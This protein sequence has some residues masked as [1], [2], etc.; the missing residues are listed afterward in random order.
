M[1]LGEGNIAAARRAI[2]ER[3]TAAGCDAPDLDAR[4]LLEHVIGTDAAALSARADEPLPPDAADRLEVLVAER[5]RGVPLAHLLGEW[6]F[7]SLPLFV[8]PDVLVPRPETELLVEWGVELLRDLPAPRIADL[9]TGSGCIALALATELPGARVDAV[10]IS[11]AALDVAARNRARHGLDDRVRLHHGDLIAPL[12]APLDGDGCYDLIVSNPPYIAPGDPKL[13][14]G[15]AAH[16]PALALF[17]P[18]GGAGLGFYDR[19]VAE[20][21]PRLA[22]GGSVI[23]ELPEDGAD[24]V[25][26][27][28]EAAGC[29]VEV[30]RD[31]AGIERALRATPA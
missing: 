12:D 20:A 2:V 30:R 22:A 27:R 18:A 19:I 15:V 26:A 5:E 7:W 8:T 3:L 13:E 21:V 23:V 31:L 25:R 14:A 29:A 28:F 17:D 4:W 10:D 1:S 9:G 16:E 6:E 11:A 24:R